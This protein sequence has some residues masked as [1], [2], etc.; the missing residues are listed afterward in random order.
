MLNLSQ[1]LLDF[2]IVHLRAIAGLRGIELASHAR[3]EIVATLT[4]ALLDPTIVEEGLRR[5]SPEERQALEALQLAGGQMRAHVFFHRFGPIRRLGPGRLERE[6]PWE[7]PAGPAES[8]WYKGFIGRRFA[9]AEDGTPEIIFIPKDLWALLPPPTR[10][11]E[12]KPEEA[13]TVDI[14]SPARVRAEGTHAVED[15]FQLL[16]YIQLHRPRAAA[17]EHLTLHDLSKL[18]ERL[19]RP[20]P[21][22]GIEHDGQTARLAF[23]H[24]LARRLGLI[25]REGS[26]LRLVPEPTRAWLSM[27]MALQQRS[28]LDTWR[29]DDSW[30]D[31]WHVPS[32]RCEPAGWKNDPRRTRD[33]FLLQLASLPAGEWLSIPAFIQRVK[34]SDPDF[35]RPDGDYRS[36]Y[37]RDA[38][39]DELL[40]GFEHWEHIEG[41][42]LVYY[43]EGPLCWLGAVDL[44][45]QNEGDAQAGVFRITEMGARFIASAPEPTLETSKQPFTLQDNLALQWADDAPLYYRFQLERFAERAGDERTYQIT[46]RSLLTARAQHI[47]P[48]DILRFLAKCLG[49]PL[50]PATEEELRRRWRSVNIVRARRLVA[51]EFSEPAVVEWLRSDA[52]MASFFTDV[53]APQRVLVSERQLPRLLA[54]LRQ[55]GLEPEIVKEK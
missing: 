30:N 18:N 34:S 31:L 21:T 55:L 5:L 39:S 14:V 32:I 23:I 50:P 12:P 43:F 48:A 40:I 2:D 37:I 7:T 38:Q 53:I 3:D 35:Q 25:Q 28:L 36:W 9:I 19:S 33:R 42:L 41:A 10:R 13:M 49:A 54:R 27:P 46:S 20:E 8:L 22:E 44:G 6:R 17:Q 11:P 26:R 45:Y 52:E 29:Q 24:H 47:Q 15:L 4:G 1:V 16:L 51:L